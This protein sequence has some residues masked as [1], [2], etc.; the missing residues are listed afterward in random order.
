MS[1]Q[2]GLRAKIFALSSLLLLLPWFAFQFISEMETLL[3]LGQ[4]QTLI[5]TTRAIAT[6]LHERPSLFNEHASFLTSVKKG[7]DLYVYTLKSPIKLDALNADWAEI[8]EQKINYP[9]A[10]K[11]ED[12]TA[13]KNDLHFKL[14]LGKHA[15]YLYAYFEVFDASPIKRQ[16]GNTLATE[17]DH[18]IIAM[19]DPQG[20]LQRYI[21][22]VMEDGWFNAYQYPA[23]SLYAK[24]LIREK[25]I[26][27][28]WKST[29]TGYN[30]E[31]RLPLTLLGDKLGF[32]LNSHSDD[33]AGNI[34]TRIETS[35]LLDIDK[36]GSVLVPSPE[37]EK[38]LLAMSHTR[39][40]LWVVDRHQRVIAK[41]GNIHQATGLWPTDI[42]EKSTT[43]SLWSRIEQTLLN[44]IYNYFLTKPDNSFID[45][46]GEQ[47]QLDNQL[48][49]QALRGES[50][51]QWRLNPDHKV[52]ILSAAHPIFVADKIM[53]VVIAEETNH[54]SLA[55]RNQALQKMF[56]VLLLVILI[57]GLL[58]FILI[59]TI[60]RRIRALRDQSALIIDE[61]GHLTGTMKASKHRDEIGDL[62]R[63]LVNVVTRLG[64][65]HHY[66]AQL[67]ARLSHELRTPVAVVRSSLENLALLPHSAE[68]KKYIQRSQ[69]GLQRLNKI[70]TSMSEANRIE[71]SLQQGEKQPVNLKQL[72]SGCLQGYA[73]VYP[74]FIFT[75]HLCKTAVMI[76]ADADFLVQL[77]D[78]LVHNAIEFSQP[79]NAI[80]IRLVAL[81]KQAVLSIDN[82]GP[83]LENAMLDDL[84]QAM[85]SVRPPSQQHD[86]HL[87]L[88]LFI[89]KMICDYHHASI[90]ILNNADLTGVTV[91]ITFDILSQ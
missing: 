14:M 67:S 86:S 50:V 43:N 2:F 33:T 42:I 28:I 80:H 87:G 84:F 52:S 58:L 74:H 13:L 51:A 22:S 63:T 30:I 8:A 64:Q 23:H 62:S 17:N 45:E 18:L 16:P 73:M 21:I 78:K 31:L 36:L 60:V 66:V 24:N 32:Q 90:C 77:L 81:P 68:Q 88:G 53:G 83:L 76:N 35:N 69:Q 56:N 57:V 54:G 70:L 29:A 10:L 61:N 59:S 47:T 39:S 4:Q 82:L 55:L 71:Q 19:S 85:V 1:F 79:E 26:Q 12:E 89:A 75:P 38:I 91:T 25:S 7:Q 34:T 6:A 27:G 15:E 9:V 3:R 46:L 44:P 11:N 65:Y 37:I 40:R 49:A 20:Q 5:G 41:A 48:V 72:V